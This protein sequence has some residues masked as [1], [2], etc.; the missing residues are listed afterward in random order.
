MKKE[1]RIREILPTSVSITP[2]GLIAN[3]LTK[4][5]FDQC[6]ALFFDEIL[7]IKEA[8]ISGIDGYGEFDE[9]CR[10]SYQSCRDFLLG[11]FNNEEEGYWYH[12]REMFD[13]KVL[14]KEFF[15]TYY[16]KMI[17]KIEY[18]EG[19]RFLINNNTFF[20]N[21]IT[22][23]QT[24]VGFPDWS[25]SG[26]GDWLIDLV[27]MDLNKPYLMVPELFVS[28]MQ[29]KKLKVTHLKE[30][31][32][33]MAYYKGLDVLRWHASIDDVESCESIMKSISSLE[34]RFDCMEWNEE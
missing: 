21:M 13:T 24:M 32:L 1:M 4:D 33:C 30:R 28:Y 11:T 2:K 23:G 15:E 26:I 8:D 10:T 16:E 18:C 14:E 7:K 31:F 29:E 12:W 27:I 25:R 20:E 17:E 19:K 6:H 3:Q 34:H 22:D 9:E 5:Q